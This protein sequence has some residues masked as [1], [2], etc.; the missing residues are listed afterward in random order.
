MTWY[1]V[2]SGQ[3]TAW[4]NTQKLAAECIYVPHIDLRIT[5]IIFLNSISRLDFEIRTQFVF[6]EL[7]AVFLNAL[8]ARKG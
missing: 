6:C 2:I 8:H 7:G 1:L 4:F 3:S 5:W